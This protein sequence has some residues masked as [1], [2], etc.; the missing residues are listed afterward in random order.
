MHAFDGRPGSGWVPTT[1]SPDSEDFSLDALGSFDDSITLDFDSPQQIALV[2]VLNG[3]G[4]SWISYMRADRVRTV[5]VSLSLGDREKPLTRR[6]SLRTLPEYEI[7]TRQKLELPGSAPVW[8]K[9]E[10]S[11]DRLKLTLPE[12]WM[13]IAVDDPH[14][15]PTIDLPT[16]Q[17]MLAKVEVWVHAEQ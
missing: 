15:I 16:H 2:C 11:Y 5:E 14:T 3:N 7:Q 9:N 13:G 1:A 6:T 12:R 10:P 8:Q 4:A 17:V